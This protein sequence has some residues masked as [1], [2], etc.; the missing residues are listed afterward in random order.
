M[1]FDR[2]LLCSRGAQVHY[3]RRSLLSLCP[4]FFFCTPG[5]VELLLKAL[6]SCLLFCK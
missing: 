3:L 5:L 6:S 1:L 2:G 4:P